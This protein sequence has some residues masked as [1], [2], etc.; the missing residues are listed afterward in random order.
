MAKAPSGK[1]RAAV[2]AIK[3]D[4]QGLETS[5]SAVH[6]LIEKG[7]YTAAEVQGKALKEKGSAVSGEIQIAIDK[8][9]GKKHASRG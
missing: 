7:D 6:Q 3:Q 8:A 4:V 5:L 9:K 2:E 1:E